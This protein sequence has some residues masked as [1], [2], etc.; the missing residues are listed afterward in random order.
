MA[1]NRSDFHYF[2]YFIISVLILLGIA[3]ILVI[4]LYRD[5]QHVT[6]VITILAGF[7][8]ALTLIFKSYLKNKPTAQEVF[9]IIPCRLNLVNFGKDAKDFCRRCNSAY[10]TFLVLGG[11]TAL[12]ESTGIHLW[13]RVDEF[14][15]KYIGQEGLLYVSIGLIAPLIIQATIYVLKHKE[16]NVLRI[17]TG[18]LFAIGCAMGGTYLFLTWS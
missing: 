8:V 16:S 10:I 5:Y 14:L 4:I 11:L 15:S 1:N 9:D 13:Q 17:L 18:I 6:Y 2:F 12:G 3:L 7:I